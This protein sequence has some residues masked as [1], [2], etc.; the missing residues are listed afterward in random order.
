MRTFLACL[1]C[2]SACAQVAVWHPTST[3]TT[4]L[5]GNVW[6]WSTNAPPSQAL[7]S[8]ALVETTTTPLAI[9]TAVTLT[10]TASNAPVLRFITLQP[11]DPPQGW[12]ALSPAVATNYV[13]MVR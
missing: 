12:Q 10:S 8:V 13:E 3:N 6:R 4:V 1:L 9:L 11:V 2:A 5:E 7:S